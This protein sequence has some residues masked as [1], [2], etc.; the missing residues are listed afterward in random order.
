MHFLWKPDNHHFVLRFVRLQVQFPD[1]F[2]ALMGVDQTLRIFNTNLAKPL[3]D[4][5]IRIFANHHPPVVQKI[6]RNR[7]FKF[8]SFHHRKNKMQIRMNQLFELFA[9]R[10]FSTRIISLPVC[11]RYILR[12]SKSQCK[13]SASG[14]TCKQLRMTYPLLIY[15]LDKPL[16]YRILA[17][18]VSK[19]H[20]DWIGKSKIAN[21]SHYESGFPKK[22][23]KS[24]TKKLTIYHLPM[25]QQIPAIQKFTSSE[26]LGLPTILFRNS[27][28]N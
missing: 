12:I 16:L 3:V 9:R 2:F 28:S 22:A 10:A 14:R 18:N 7:F 19:K 23:G 17:N 25:P 26:R 15:R 8:W 21:Q 24:Q 5:E 27:P 1:D 11:T 13:L 20:T 4:I 6:I